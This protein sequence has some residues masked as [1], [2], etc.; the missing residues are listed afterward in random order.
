MDFKVDALAKWVIFEVL[1]LGAENGLRFF[2]TVVCPFRPKTFNDAR[3]FFRSLL[4]FFIS[5]P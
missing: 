4:S 5:A 3:C 1:C 2:T